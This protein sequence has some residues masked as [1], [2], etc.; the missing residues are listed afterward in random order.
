MLLEV[1]K[2]HMIRTSLVVAVKRYDDDSA[3][4]PHKLQ[5]HS[6]NSLCPIE[7]NFIKRDDRDTVYDKLKDT[8]DTLERINVLNGIT[9]C[10]TGK[11]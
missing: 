4:K 5:I 8:L 2:D 6:A 3:D 11:I 9:L 7:L 1:N 10:Q